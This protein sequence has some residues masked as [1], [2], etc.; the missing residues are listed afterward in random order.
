MT[1]PERWL[2]GRDDGE[3]LERDLLAS[4]RSVNP[5]VGAK[6]DAWEA[7]GARIAGAAVIGTAAATG[8]RAASFGLKAAATKIV[9]GVALAG[10]AVGGAAV[11][12]HVRAASHVAPAAARVA[13]PTAPVARPPAT[14][15]PVVA[16]PSPPV[17]SPPPA[18]S[19]RAPVERAH[20]DR[21]G[22]ESALL[23]EARAELRRGDVS[24]AQ[25]T[26]GRMQ[27]SMPN[28]VLGQER[29]VLAIEVLAAEGKTDAAR[30][31]A[32]AFVEAHPESPHNAKLGRFL[33]DP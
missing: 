33:D 22:A 12:V 25:A 30:R 18:S 15:A 23:T 6:D 7:V 19:A 20:G 14:A 8:L 10:A 17:A 3:A 27:T 28:G 24:A 29:E 31:R 4:L 32:R 5:P 21:L 1:D 2:N 11:W 13:E 9:L 26:L 16:E